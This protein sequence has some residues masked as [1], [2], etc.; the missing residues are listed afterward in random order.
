MNMYANDEPMNQGRNDETMN[1]EP[2]RKYKLV[3]SLSL[4]DSSFLCII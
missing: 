4:T 1:N 3:F 2:A